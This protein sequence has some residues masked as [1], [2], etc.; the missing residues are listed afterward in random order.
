MQF[1]RGMRFSSTASMNAIAL[2]PQSPQNPEPPVNH[3]RIAI[4][5]S[6][7]HST[8]KARSHHP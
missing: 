8:S 2:T 1:N 5:S 7:S 3:E 6:Q 4:A